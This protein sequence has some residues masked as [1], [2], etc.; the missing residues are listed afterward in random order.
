MLFILFKITAQLYQQMT[1]TCYLLTD[2]IV[3]LS[4]II[5]MAMI[6]AIFITLFLL[7]NI[8]LK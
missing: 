7:Y 4:L 6:R 3:R 1:M 5:H 2:Y 8:T